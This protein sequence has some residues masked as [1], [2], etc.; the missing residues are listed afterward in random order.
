MTTT[1][2]LLKEINK[3]LDTILESQKTF[4]PLLNNKL[5]ELI[6]AYNGLN[7]SV[8]NVSQL[9]N[10]FGGIIEDNK[11]TIKSIAEQMKMNTEKVQ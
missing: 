4:F 7:E 5:S 11:D 8:K 6:K 9:G 10:M 1:E 2:Q 3:K